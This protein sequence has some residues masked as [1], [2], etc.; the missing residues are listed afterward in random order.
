M[1]P[2]ESIMETAENRRIDRSSSAKHMDARSASIYSKGQFFLVSAI[3][4]T[5]VFL[6]ISM[7]FRNYG[8]VD[9]SETARVNEDVYFHNIKQQFSSVVAQSSC[10]DMDRNLR[11]YREF[12]QRETNAV[13]Y[14]LFLNYTINNCAAK[15]V[16]LQ[17]IVASN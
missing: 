4:I 9:N 3:M 8:I 15:Q 12:V 11:D 14:R 10:P 13:G 17:L 6:V 16:D 5:G 2:Q 7:L 1:P